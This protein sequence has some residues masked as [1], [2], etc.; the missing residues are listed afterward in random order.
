VKGII[1]AG[2]KGTRLYPSTLATSKQLLPVYNKPMVYYPL[3]TLMMAGIRTVLV[4]S[5]P[6]DLPQYERLLGDGSQWGMNFV[7]A[8][9]DRPRGLA[10][11][12]VLGRP[13]VH[14][15]TCLI[16]GDNIFFG[17][18]FAKVVAQAAA[19]VRKGSCGA[20]I[21]GYQVKDPERY[22][23]V[24]LDAK[25]RATS[26]EEKPK[27]PKSKLAVPGLYFY[28]NRVTEIAASLNPSPRGEIEITDVNRVYMERNDLR[29][30]ELGRGTAWLD[31]GTHESLLQASNF[32]Q[33]IE[34]RQG[35][36]I[37]SPEEVAFRMGFIGRERLL[38]HAERFHGT[39]AECLRHA[40]AL[41]VTAHPIS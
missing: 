24:E 15:S 1:L 18:D 35:L 38:E 29:V 3:T 21:F 13:F 4:I 5:T 20:A 11:A 37:G 6:E 25:G 26:I 9:Q 36:L 2:G 34:E 12:F 39:Y 8:S 32:I 22:G 31:A 17:H 10:D 41:P 16:L 19:D 40:A 28:D 27:A 7:Y 14:E 30:F 23:V 33:T